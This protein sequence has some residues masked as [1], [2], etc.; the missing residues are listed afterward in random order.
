MDLSADD[1]AGD[2]ALTLSRP[3]RTDLAEQRHSHDKKLTSVL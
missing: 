3:G 1:V 2:G